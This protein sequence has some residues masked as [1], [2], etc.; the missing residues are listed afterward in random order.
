MNSKLLS[1]REFLRIGGLTGAGVLLAACTPKATPAPP[2]AP[3]E[4]PAAP[5]EAPVE[6]TAA[7]AEPTEAPPAAVEEATIVYLTW[8]ESNDPHF[9]YMAERWNEEHTAGPRLKMEYLR[10]GAGDEAVTKVMN[11][12]AAGSGVPDIFPIETSQVSKFLKGDP[13]LFEQHL[14]EITPLLDVFN[15]NWKEDYIG[16]SSYTWQGK[17]FAVEVGLAP[18]GYYYRK[19]LFDEVGIEMPLET[20]EDWMAAGAKMAEAGH[21]TVSYTH[22]TLPTIYS[23]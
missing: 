12:I 5:T 13:P 11:A 6:P 20:W 23:V 19:D 16:F 2:A 15:P 9:N 1:R 18:C 21:A 10:V 4:A 3:T 17:V 7:P 8:S 14:L 22:L